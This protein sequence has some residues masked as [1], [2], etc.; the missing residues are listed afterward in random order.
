M[1]Y[2]YL[3]VTPTSAS[4]ATLTPTSSIASSCKTDTNQSEYTAHLK[5]SDI[6][7]NRSSHH[8]HNLS[9]ASQYSASSSDTAALSSPA[10]KSH[11]YHLQHHHLTSNGSRSLKH[12]SSW[13]SACYRPGNTH[14]SS[15]SFSPQQQ[16]N[17][18]FLNMDVAKRSCHLSFLQL[19]VVGGLE[20]VVLV[21][22]C[23]MVTWWLQHGID[24]MSNPA[25]T[26]RCWDFADFAASDC[27]FLALYF[28]LFLVAMLYQ[29]VMVVDSAINKNAA[30][31]LATQLFNIACFVYSAIQLKQ[32]TTIYERQDCT[33]ILPPWIG[34]RLEMCI[35]LVIAVVVLMFF[36]V[37]AGVFMAVLLFKDYRWS[38]YTEK[39]GASISKRNAI[40]RHHFFL[41]FL[42]LNIFFS[43]AITVMLGVAIYFAT[44]YQP[45]TLEPADLSVDYTGEIAL[46]TVIVDFVVLVI[47]C[48]AYYGMGLLAVRKGSR[49][50]MGLFLGLMV[51]DFCA[52]GY[53]LWVVRMDVRFEGTVIFLTWFTS[54]EI[55]V[56]F[57]T[58]Y[59]GMLCWKDFTNFPNYVDM[60]K[61]KKSKFNDLDLELK[62][63]V[64]PVL[65]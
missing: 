31:A 30:Q 20:V 3:P 59:V 44:S 13:G 62:P 50:T 29:F 36:F 34:Q 8:R 38:I 9:I 42:K 60:I 22:T 57:A 19:L 33:D 55:V 12:A 26:G 48:L 56:N 61:P 6:H 14:I 51:I 27:A 47:V 41:L 43:L 45:H 11:H 18:F 28:C 49:W 32:L 65:D 5:S 15:I 46:G 63:R 52:L 35:D 64:I 16:R 25:A 4:T 23:T 53:I 21:F 2:P 40:R 1:H 10:H 54:I 58:M 39:S 37:S 17:H 24:V 7:D